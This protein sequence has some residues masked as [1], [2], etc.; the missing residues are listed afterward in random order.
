MDTPLTCIGTYPDKRTKKEDS[1][2]TVIEWLDSEYNL[3]NLFFATL[4]HLKQQAKLAVTDNINQFIIGREPYLTQIRERLDFLDYILSWSDLMLTSQQI[5]LLWDY[6]I[7]QAQSA[8]ERDAGF[9]W[10]E[11][12]RGSQ[13]V[14]LFLMFFALSLSFLHLLMMRLQTIYLMINYLLLT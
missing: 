9:Q 13:K 12:A 8:E 7:L 4:L 2:P 1:I 3:L 10:L 11:N 5:D 6:I 14:A